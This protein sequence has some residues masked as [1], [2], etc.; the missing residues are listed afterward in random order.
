MDSSYSEFLI[1]LL[2]FK[3][4]YV[5]ITLFLQFL[6]SQRY[7]AENKPSSCHSVRRQANPPTGVIGIFQ[8]EGYC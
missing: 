3:F 8:L 5:V 4:T 2:T 6:V 1:W 7:Y